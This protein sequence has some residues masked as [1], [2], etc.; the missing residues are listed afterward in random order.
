MFLNIYFSIAAN[1][2]VNPIVSLFSS[3]EKLV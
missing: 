1:T 2:E 3:F